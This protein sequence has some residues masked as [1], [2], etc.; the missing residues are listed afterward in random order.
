[1]NQKKLYR[2]ETNKVLAGVCGGIAEYLNIDATIVRLIMFL[3]C[4][5]QLGIIFYIAAAIIIPMEPLE[6]YQPN[7][8]NQYTGYYEGN[9]A[10]G[11]NSGN[12]A[13]ANYNNFNTQSN[14]NTT[15]AN[16]H[17]ANQDNQTEYYD[18]KKEDI[19]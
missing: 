12:N 17:E 15:Q 3:L 1:M 16:H 6:R 4:I 7:T 8:N 13:D 14:N 11:N 19:F 10:Y 5:G 2:S 18:V 9:H